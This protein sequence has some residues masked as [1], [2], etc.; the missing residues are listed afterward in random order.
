MDGKSGTGKGAWKREI[1]IGTKKKKKT[2]TGKDHFSC[3]G[4][5]RKREKEFFPGTH[6]FPRAKNGYSASSLLQ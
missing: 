4:K 1:G 6:V 3:S 2:R 5:N